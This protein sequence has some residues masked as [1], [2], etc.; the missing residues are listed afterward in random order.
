MVRKI[1][2]ALVVIVAAIGAGLFWL[3]G[4]LDGLIRDGIARYGSAM[5]QATVSVGSVEIRGS[6]GA[7]FIRNLHIGNPQGFKTP[8]ALKV[9]E[10]E[11]AI[12]PASLARDVIVIR[13]IAIKAPDVIYEKGDAMT[14]FDALQKNIAAYL[15][16]SERKEG[17]GKKL[18]VEEL[19][20]RDARAEVSAPF[21]QGKAATVNLPDITLR[22]LGK[23]KGGLPPGEL[24]QEITQALKQRLSASV[25]FEGLARSA[26]SA[27]GKAGEAV[28][29]LLG[30]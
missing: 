28:K 17:D 13:R 25:N 23:S 26:G 1:V 20:I 2:I 24:G 5:T 19:T 29:G 6:D 30:Q 21:M 10:I 14:N 8:H 27:L 15:G 9:A 16:L 18:I 22:N 7:G 11:V 12:D 4:S 3:R